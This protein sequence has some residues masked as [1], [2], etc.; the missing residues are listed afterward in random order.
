MSSVFVVSV[1]ETRRLEAEAVQSGTSLRE[2]MERAGR[3][4]A[5]AAVREFAL[6]RGASVLVLVGPG[7]NGGDGLVAGRE[8]ARLGFKV[9]LY[10]WK[11]PWGPDE[12]DLFP[13]G[14]RIAEVAQAKEDPARDWLVRSA[15]SAMVIVDALLGVGLN[16]PL[17]GD[18]VDIISSLARYWE[19][20]LAID[21]PTGIG[22]DDGAI[23]GTAVR[24]A[25]TVTMGH[26]K[27]C[28]FLFPAAAMRGR[29]VVAD[30]GLPS[31]PAG[32][33]SVLAPDIIR[34]WLPERPADAHKG[35]FGKV[36]VVGGSY[37]Y[38]GAPMLAAEAAMRGGAGLVCVAMPRSAYSAN[39]GRTREVTYLPLPEMEMVV[40][41]AAARVVLEE[42][43]SYSAVLL[44]P[45]LTTEVEAPSFVRDVLSLT[46]RAE[47]PPLGFA[48]TPR[49]QPDKKGQLPPTVLD[50][51]GL[52][53]VAGLDRWWESLPQKCVITPHVGELARLTGLETS[54]VVRQ[55]ITLAQ[56]LA[57]EWGLTM[58]LKGAYTLVSDDTGRLAVNPYANPVLA[59]AGS[60]DVL[61]GLVA[62]FLAQRMEPFEAA[63][64]SVF[65]HSE[66]AE[67][68][69]ASV[70]DR[71]MLA[72]D[73][74]A[75]I[76]EVVRD[77]VA[78]RVPSKI[79]F[80]QVT[81][82]IS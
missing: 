39:A 28:H 68:F 82:G 61:A 57:R 50:A 56:R 11:R 48:P 46:G 65:I 24:A 55:R 4:V 45:G 14:Q 23:Y 38:L 67:R 22:P 63:A 3:A 64:A 8:L 33:G 21:V 80:L 34:S 18:I 44:G 53:A 79:G 81:D 2:L 17:E 41:K 77:I 16:R 32:T 51:D 74:L 15:E 49:G 9:A 70:G 20:V 1:D 7:N 13:G 35:T 69:A 62:G 60:G 59:T 19:K 12:E 71:G 66:A 26:C 42:V 10:L 25:V 78:D 72:G 5:E 54:A 27:W 75:L 52:N 31:P 30:I 40:S 29:L 73:L 76:P 36:L 58:I 47:K 6:S 37:R 43:A